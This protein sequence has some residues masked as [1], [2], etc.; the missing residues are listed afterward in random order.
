MCIAS[1]VISTN[2][3]DDHYLP[4]LGLYYAHEQKMAQGWHIVVANELQFYADD[5]RQFLPLQ[6]AIFDPS[7]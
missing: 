7:D 2:V 1:A 4:R 3:V 5:D 6:K